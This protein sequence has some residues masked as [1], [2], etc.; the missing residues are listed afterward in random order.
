MLDTVNALLWTT[1]YKNFM[2][3]RKADPKFGSKPL[4]R[5]EVLALMEK[6]AVLKMSTRKRREKLIENLDEQVK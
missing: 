4:P 3:K 6:Q 5:E 1:F 2:L